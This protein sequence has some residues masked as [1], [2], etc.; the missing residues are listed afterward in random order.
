[1]SA[2]EGELCTRMAASVHVQWGDP[3]S[4][5]P[6]GLLSGQTRVLSGAASSARVQFRSEVVTDK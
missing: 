4:S 1:M 5:G 3:G 2:G 6:D